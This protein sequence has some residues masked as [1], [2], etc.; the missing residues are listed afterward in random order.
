MTTDVWLGQ[1][2]NCVDVA[3]ELDAGRISFASRRPS[4]T[5]LSSMKFLLFRRLRCPRCTILYGSWRK[6]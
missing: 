5:K 6:L 3:L 2:P 4:C 1:R